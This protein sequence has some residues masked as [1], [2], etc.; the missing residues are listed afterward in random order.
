MRLD[1][2][3]YEPLQPGERCLH[4][5]EVHLGVVAGF[6]VR[7][8]RARPNELACWR[9]RSTCAAACRPCVSSPKTT[10]ST[11][12]TRHCVRSSPNKPRTWPSNANPSKVRR[13][14][15]WLRQAFRG[16]GKYDP[17]LAVGRDGIHTPMTHGEYNEGEHGDADRLQ[18]PGQASGHGLS[19]ADAWEQQNHPAVSEQYDGFAHRRAESV[20]WRLARGWRR[21]SAM[22]AGTRRTTS[23]RVLSR[24]SRGP[25]VQPGKLLVWQ[26][27]VDFYHAT[28][29]VTKLAEALLLAQESSGNAAMG[30]ADAACAQRGGRTDAGAAIGVV[31]SAQAGKWRGAPRVLLPRRTTTCTRTASTWTM[32]GIVV[33]EC[34]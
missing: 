11:G 33:R 25:R 20:A 4:P 24:M 18:P 17:V 12:R 22:L 28:L 14:I 30:A 34:R 31:L 6:Y 26:R 32:R 23:P 15:D 3:L 5:L 19:G 7:Q 27:V 16:K 10:R 13:L 8:F 9:H 2:L 29:Y 1:R 21:T